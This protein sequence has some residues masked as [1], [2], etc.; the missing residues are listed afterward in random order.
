MTDYTGLN[1]LKKKNAHHPIALILLKICISYYNLYFQKFSVQNCEFCPILYFRFYHMNPAFFEEAWV[2]LRLHFMFYDFIDSVHRSNY[3]RLTLISFETLT[4]LLGRFSGSPRFRGHFLC[5]LS[6]W[7]ALMSWSFESPP[8][9]GDMNLTAVPT[10]STWW[11]PCL[12]KPDFRSLYMLE[13]YWPQF[14]TPLWSS[15]QFAR[16]WSQGWS[17]QCGLHIC[18]W[19]TVTVSCMRLAGVDVTVLCFWFSFFS[20]ICFL[21]TKL[22]F[23]GWRIKMQNEN[24]KDNEICRKC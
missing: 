8:C 7:Y 14:Q 19:D 16:T 6:G 15:C 23:W 20:G 1:T 2:C 11:W 18:G 12:H 3:F 21:S 17:F 13:V 24:M 4:G 10:G 22:T 5:M 9:N